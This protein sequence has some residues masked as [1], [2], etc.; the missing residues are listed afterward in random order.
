MTT[1]D[2]KF[3]FV[4]CPHCECDVMIHKN[5]FNC[6]I[7]RHGAYKK[8]GKQINPHL[9]KENC[10]ELASSDK[11][12]GCGKPFRLVTNENNVVVAKICDYI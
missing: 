8:T 1:E 7:F 3:S 6:K 11:I 10:D 12:Y 2:E 5:E 4:T 9:K